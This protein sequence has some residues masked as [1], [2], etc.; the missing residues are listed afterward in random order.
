MSN[1]LED[2]ESVKFRMR[3]EGIGYCFES[4]INWY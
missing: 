1:N 4:Y 3:N 2:W